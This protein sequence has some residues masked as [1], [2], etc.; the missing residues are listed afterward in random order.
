MISRRIISPI[1]PWVRRT[2]AIHQAVDELNT[3]RRVLP[4]AKPRISARDASSPTVRPY[5]RP[6]AGGSPHTARVNEGCS[7]W[8]SLSSTQGTSRGTE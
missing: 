7:H 1:R 5:V 8:A 2:R 3:E 4:L 6:L